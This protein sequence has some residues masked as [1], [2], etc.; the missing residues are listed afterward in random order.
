MADLDKDGATIRDG[1]FILTDAAKDWGILQTWADTWEE[2]LA[3]LF[4]D[5]VTDFYP[6]NMLSE[7]RQSPYLTRLPKGIKELLE[8]QKSYH[9]G[10][11]KDGHPAV[12]GRYMHLQLSPVQ[13]KV[14][15][16]KKV[17]PDMRHSFLKNDEWLQACMNDK[18][19]QEWHLKTHWKIILTGTR[20]A[21]MFNH[22][23]ALLTSS[24][25]LHVLGR[26]WWYVCGTHAD[27]RQVCYEDN[28]APGEILYYPR[29]WHHET[30]CLE[31][32]TMTLT[33]TVAH[34]GNAEGIMGKAFGE[35]SNKASLSFDFSSQ[36]CDALDECTKWW[37]RRTGETAWHEK[38][39]EGWRGYADAAH[40]TKIEKVKPEHNN[41]DG[42]NYITEM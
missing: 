6:Y 42:R 10:E 7:S 17:I 12:E 33:D 38:D 32:P 25:H 27:G 36:L 11:P 28:L 8:P 2:D 19:A 21:G 1:P 20:G 4:P 39:H 40:I 41:Y 3:E 26:K 31:T 13:W 22:S 37:R 9:F 14:L 18:V 30:Q 29:R 24:W 16:D 23:D 15:E 34:E 35:C 5:A